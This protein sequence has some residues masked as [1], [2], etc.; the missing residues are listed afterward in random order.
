MN[1]FDACDICTSLPR[2]VFGNSEG[3]DDD[4]VRLAMTA[5]LTDLHL[6]ERLHDHYYKCGTCGTYWRFESRLAMQSYLSHSHA[7]P[8]ELRLIRLTHVEAEGIFHH[9]EHEESCLG[10]ESRW[11]RETYQSRMSEMAETLDATAA[12]AR[13]FAAETLADDYKRSKQ[14]DKVRELI[15]HPDPN[16][17]MGALWS[18]AEI[19][20]AEYFMN[21]PRYRTYVTSWDKKPF[22]KPGLVLRDFATQAC[23]SEPQIRSVAASLLKALWTEKG[24][25]AA[26]LSVPAE[27]WSTELKCLHIAHLYSMS[28]QGARKL[29]TYLGDGDPE[30]RNAALSQI[31]ESCDRRE[32]VELVTVEIRKVR[33]AARSEEMKTFLKDPERGFYSDDDD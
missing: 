4:A 30:V 29:V 10:E 9:G 3:D 7:Y 17:R 16:V 13:E 24:Y 25:V 21:S 28:L 22:M 26:L 2:V 15:N 11:T 6:K 32:F 20:W 18:F 14:H 31:Y 12:V 8:R 1:Q 33:V 19:P 27:R 23:A 5:K